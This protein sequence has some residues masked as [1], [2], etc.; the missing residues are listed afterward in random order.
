MKVGW[1][2]SL[3]GNRSRI[4]DCQVFH[5]F[6]SKREVSKSAVFFINWAASNFL[7][8]TMQASE[9][10]RV[11]SLDAWGWIGGWAMGKVIEFYIPSKYKRQN[12]WVPQEKRGKLLVFPEEIKKS[13]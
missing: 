4:S 13:A 12:K 7:R 9:V 5:R 10:V 6:R 2:N 1:L 11:S 8:A 3:K